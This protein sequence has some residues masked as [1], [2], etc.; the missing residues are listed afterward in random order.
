MTRSGSLWPVKFLCA[1]LL[2]IIFLYISA[3]VL[4]K[5]VTRFS[6][7][8]KIA[9]EVSRHFLVDVVFKA[10]NYFLILAIVTFFF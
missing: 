1:A 2:C 10:F 3:K 4:L 9:R 6:L 8:L 7:R 5:V